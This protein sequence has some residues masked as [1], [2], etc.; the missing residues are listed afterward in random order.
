M[1]LLRT[2]DGWRTWDPTP[3]AAG[4]VTTKVFVDR[5]KSR[6][7][8]K[9]ERESKRLHKLLLETYPAIER[10]LSL[11]RRDGVI[12][13]SGK[14]LAIIEPTNEDVP[15][16]LK[17]NLAVLNTSNISKEQIAESFS[18]GYASRGFADIE[19]AG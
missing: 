5:D 7:Q 2:T 14:P 13:L 11:N 3:T 16:V 19:W 8:I 10:T 15:G 4:G 17:W 6:A 12:S 18:K 9:R 1:Q